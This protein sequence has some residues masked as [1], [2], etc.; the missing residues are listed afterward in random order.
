MDIEI[1]NFI[2]IKKKTL[3]PPPQNVTCGF[4]LFL[5]KLSKFSSNIR[6][7]EQICCGAEKPL[8]VVIDGVQ[9]PAIENAEQPHKTAKINLIIILYVQ[10]VFFYQHKIKLNKSLAKAS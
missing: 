5:S 8:A 7:P 4:H 1:G 9:P 10:I 3:T 6:F 2:L